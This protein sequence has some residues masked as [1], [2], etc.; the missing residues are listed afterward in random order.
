MCAYAAPAAADS[1][2][3]VGLGP[4]LKVQ[5]VEDLEA[6]QSLPLVEEGYQPRLWSL[7][8]SLQ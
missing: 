1:I 4:P 3:S 7:G 5:Q 6:G 2:G 8:T